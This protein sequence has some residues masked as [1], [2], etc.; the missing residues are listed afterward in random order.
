MEDESMNMRCLEAGCADILVLPLS[1][2]VAA[3]E[4]R[5]AVAMKNSQKATDFIQAHKLKVAEMHVC[6]L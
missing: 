3:T 6:I 2:N 1:S 4:F 5:L